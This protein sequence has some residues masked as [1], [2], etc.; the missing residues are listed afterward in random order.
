MEEYNNLLIRNARILDSNQR[1]LQPSDIRIRDGVITEIAEKIVPE[2]SCEIWEVEGAYVS[3]GWVDAHTHF[4]MEAN[5]LNFNANKIYPHDG[6]TLA[7][8]AGSFGTTNFKQLIPT[9]ER[10]PILSKAY[11]HVTKD[12]ASFLGKELKTEDQLDEDRF[13][14][15]YE[16]YKNRIIGVKVRI[17]PRVNCFMLESLHR[18]RKIA[19]KLGLPLI[20]HP[21]RCTES[22][23]D[24]LAVLQKN[25]VYA[26]TYSKLTPCILDKNGKVKD[27]VWRARERGVWFDLSHGSNNFSFEVAKKAMEQDFVVNTISTDLHA[28]NITAPVRSMTDVMTKMLALGMPLEEIIQRVTVAPVNMLGIDVDKGTIAVGQK[29][30]LTVFA[31]RQGKFI[32]QDSYQISLEAN[33]S[34]E[35]LGTIYGTHFYESRKGIFFTA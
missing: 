9:M 3:R 12:G 22:L 20:I 24:I 1:A 19:D 5:F 15:T 32:L 13:Y 8:D 14:E 7:V 30:D 33:Q 4:F 17:D 34:I 27:C 11:L 18:S 2:S 21:T 29:A 6:I 35:V 10:L 25:D 31:L 28:M 23:E 16:T 26:H